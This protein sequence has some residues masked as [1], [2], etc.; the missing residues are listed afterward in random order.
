M[1]KVFI[2]GSRRLSRLNTDVKS[3]L[4]N[5]VN[6]GLT[7][8]VGDAN[9]ADRA[10]QQYLASKGHDNVIVFCAARGCRNNIG[11]WP[12]RHVGPS[13]EAR[14]DFAYYATKDRV[15]VDETDYG[16]MLW[17]GR[18]R[19][20]LTSIVDLM[21]Q[22]KPVVVYF[23]PGKSFHTLRNRED[24]AAL[25]RWVDPDILQRIERDLHAAGRPGPAGPH[26]RARN[27]SLF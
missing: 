26:Q 12:A 13:H 2:G 24:L 14:R 27:M 7:V 5:I 21:R 23:A 25:L 19:G 6:N 15:M 9:G 4:D 3:R 16:L 1:S 11:K 10:V 8:L 22:G 17:D 20:T 18:S